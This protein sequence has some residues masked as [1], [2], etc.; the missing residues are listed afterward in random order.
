MTVGL[1]LGGQ[2]GRRATAQPFGGLR[3]WAAACRVRCCGKVLMGLVGRHRS[4]CGADPHRR[5]DP[6][7]PPR[8]WRSCARARRR[9]PPPWR[10][11]A[12][13]RRQSWRAGCNRCGTVWRRRRTAARAQPRCGRG[14]A[15][16]CGACRGLTVGLHTRLVCLW[17]RPGP[18]GR[19]GR[20]GSWG[21]PVGCAT[22]WLP[23]E[24]ARRGG[25]GRGRARDAGGAAR[26]ARHVTGEPWA[27]GR[28]QRATPRGA[29]F[30]CLVA[31]S[32]SRDGYPASHATGT[33]PLRA[34]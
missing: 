16:G 33:R 19:E 9:R 15:V 30:T 22:L 32:N 27:R 34:A 21:G 25:G 3:K 28:V 29:R 11:C 2:A 20:A 7:G 6:H 18:R 12:A 23:E 14:L 10:R 24:T 13:G 4:S 1:C 17:R 31:S 5:C 8:R 26:R